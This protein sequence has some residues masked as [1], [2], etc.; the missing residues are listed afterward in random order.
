MKKITLSV[1]GMHC[2]A[3]E[4]CVENV[5]MALKGVKST[6]A[7]YARASV[8]AEYDETQA[9]TGR[10]ERAITEAGYT[11][12]GDRAA[13]AERRYAAPYRHTGAAVRGVY[14]DLSHRRLQL[15]T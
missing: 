8:K 6:K 1:Q 3:C 11:V 7:S 2:A 14:A 15:H 5:L 4:L 9:D 13:K 12:S 10:M